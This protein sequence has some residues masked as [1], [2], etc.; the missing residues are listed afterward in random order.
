M[1]SII[2]IVYK[3]NDTYTMFFIFPSSL[4]TEYKIRPWTPKYIHL[5]MTAILVVYH[6]RRIDGEAQ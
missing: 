4:L 3:L 6:V 1:L 2:H 5:D